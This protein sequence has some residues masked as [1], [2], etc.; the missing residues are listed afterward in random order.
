MY[1]IKK[2]PIEFFI[3]RFKEGFN[4]EEV[5]KLFTQGNC[6]HFAVIL[7]NLYDGEIYHDNIVN[8]FIFK[9]KNKFYDI[10]GEVDVKNKDISKLIDIE[11]NDPSHFIILLRDCIYKINYFE[12]I[13]NEYCILKK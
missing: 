9:H 7:S 3:E 12:G 13:P 5:I 6:Y 10:T 8:H 4:K 2:L 11:I 1:K